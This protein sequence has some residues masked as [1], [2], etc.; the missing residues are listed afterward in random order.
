MGTVFWDVEGCI[1]ID[2]LLKVETINVACY[3]QTFKK[4]NL[5]FG[6]SAR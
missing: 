4:P 5:H 3:V 1:P 2:F 6:K